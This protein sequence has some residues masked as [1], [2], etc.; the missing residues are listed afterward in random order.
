MEVAIPAPVTPSAGTLDSAPGVAEDEEPVPD[1]VDEVC[2]DESKRDG[3]DV[4]EGLKVAAKGEV[5]KERGGAVVECAE[6]GDRAGE[7]VAVDG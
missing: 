1:N 2:S 5:E 3:A 7:D 6:E 4:V